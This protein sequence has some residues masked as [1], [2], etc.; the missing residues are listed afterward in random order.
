LASRTDTHQI[1]KKGDGVVKKKRLRTGSYRKSRWQKKTYVRGTR[2]QKAAQK[3]NGDSGL[4]RSLQ[5]RGKK[6]L[7]VRVARI[8]EGAKNSRR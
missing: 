1:G 7:C 2:L 4:W 6:Y 3:A 8:L 5:S